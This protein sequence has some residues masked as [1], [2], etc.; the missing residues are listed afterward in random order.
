MEG[1]ILTFIILSPISF[2]LVVYRYYNH[3]QL[4]CI[5][6]NNIDSHNQVIPEN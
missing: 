4:P 5:D 6:T 3:G 2:C 1:A